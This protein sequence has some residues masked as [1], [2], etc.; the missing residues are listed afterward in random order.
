MPPVLPE[1]KIFEQKWPILNQKLKHS[2]KGNNTLPR[3][4]LG[5][6][7]TPLTTATPSVLGSP[8]QSPKYATGVPFFKNILGLSPMEGWEWC[9]MVYFSY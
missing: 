5:G 7:G 8:L 3:P 2:E 4:L 6:R 9:I 1:R